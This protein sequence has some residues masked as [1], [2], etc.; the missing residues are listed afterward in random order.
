L[1]WAVLVWLS[2]FWKQQWTFRL[3]LLLFCDVTRHRFA[4][5]IDI[6]V[7]IFG[8]IFKWQPDQF[9]SW[10]QLDGLFCRVH[11]RG[12]L[13]LKEVEG[14]Y[15]V[16][17]AWSYHQDRVGMMKE[18][19]NEEMKRRRRKDSRLGTW[20]RMRKEIRQGT[21]RQMEVRMRK[22]RRQSNSGKKI[23]QI[24]WVTDKYKNSGLFEL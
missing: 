17:G 11:C 14:T 1:T 20:K 21:G 15:Q 18:K 13:I 3:R 2:M 24:S 19:N 8:P 22:G 9:E 6:S 4:L 12:W 5:V 16:A 23:L 10:D 7:H